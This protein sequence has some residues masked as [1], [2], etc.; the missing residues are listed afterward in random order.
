MTHSPAEAA[1]LR[2]V[3]AFKNPTLDLLHGRYAP[4]V[5]AV[6][7]RMFS[8][9]R[10]S[11]PVADAHVEVGAFVEE[12]R[13]A[14]VATEDR[15]IPAGSGREICRYW[16]RVG[17]L[18]PHI[19][20]GI[21]LY[22]L[23]AQAV[24]ALE[25]AGR[26]GGGRAKVSRSRVR[27]LL[28]SV[29]QLTQSAETDPGKRLARLRA[30]RDEI[31]AEIALLERDEVP[32]EPIDDD[33]LLEDTE[34][35]LHLSRE[36]PADF[37]R[38]AES[39]NAMQRDVIAELRRDE[40]PA[41]EVLRE[42]LQR[43][44]HVMDATPEGRAFSG[45]L[46]LIGDPEHID[47]LTD[48]LQGILA[49]PFTRLMSAEQRGDLRAIAKR[50]EQGVQEVL[51]AQRRASHVITTQVRTHDPIRDREVDDLLRGVMAGLQSWMPESKAG[52]RVEPLRSLPTGGIGHLRQS[53][54]DLRPP[55]PPAPLRD[56]AADAEFVDADT[57]AWGGPNY[58]DLEKYLAGLDSERFD[59]ATA[60][61]GIAADGARRPADLLG[62]LELAHR[63][64]SLE[65][66][67]V[68]VVE[69]IRPDGTSRRFAF[70]AVTART[71]KEDADVD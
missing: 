11:V 70:A 62:L 13:A 27:T 8:A 15:Q 58:G 6:L 26:A 65:G 49:Q 42:Y 12:I 16:V 21:E 51:N 3:A 52:D 19:H 63:N 5:V 18:V 64:G 4:F 69:A 22:R 50:V 20:E 44:E 9:E 57:R 24:G 38:V 33:Q 43:G 2:A 47:H 54:N 23:S 71:L 46:K 48:Q 35:I 45:A 14:G 68:S 25:V 17:W 28:E 55:N 60:F 32:F 61:E 34:N 40:R 31:D 10:A 30:E 67:T 7:T 36:L 56:A 39:I 37:V 59:L 66:D 1:Y 53:L 29:E 41:G